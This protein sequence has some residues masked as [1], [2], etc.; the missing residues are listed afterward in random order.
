MQQLIQDLRYAV[1]GLIKRP[2]FTLIA[3]M[4]LA[5]G[6]GANSAIFSVVDGVL[7]RSL[8]L[9]DS[10]SLY[11]VHMGLATFNRFDG[12]LSYPEYQD[13]VQQTRSFQSIGAWVDGDAN[14]SEGGTAER[15]MIRIVLPSLLP[16]LGVE[17]VRGRNFL[18]EETAKGRDHVALIT[19]GLWQRRFSGSEDVIGKPIYLDNV[20][21]QI[22]GVLPHDFQFEKP[23]DLWV[24]LTTTD[25]E[26][27]VRNAHF[28]SVIGRLRPGVSEKSAAAD[29]SAVAK[30]ESA[31]FPD[32]FPPS[33]GFDFRARPYLEDIVGD[34]RLPLYVLLAAVGFVLLIACTNVANLLLA[35]AAPR[36]REIALRTALGARRWHLMR[37]LLTE[38]IL[39]AIIAGGIGVLLATWGTSALVALSPDSLPRAR[40]IGFDWRVLAFTGVIALTTGIVFGLLPAI[41]GPRV[42]LTDALKEGSRGSTAGS[43]RLRKILVV[44]EVALSLML[45]VGAGLMVRSF[46]HL[47]SVNPG[48]QTDHALTLRVSLPVPNSQISAADEDRFMSF[49]D[50]ALARLSELP[51]VTAAGA[52]NMIPLD[53]NGTDRLIEIEGYVPRDQSDMPDAQNRQATPGFFA[54]MGIPL[55]RGRLIERSDDNKAARVLVVN[56]E[57]VKRFFPN[58]DAIGKRIRLGKLT[59]DFPWAT[60]VGVVGDVRG[61]ALDE[62][63]EPTMYWPVAQIRATPS[64]TIVVRTLSDPAALAPS[65]RDAIAEIDG[66]QPIYD[67]QPLDQLVAKSLGQ[68]RF[69]LML[70][71]LFGVIALVL[72]AIGIYGVMAFAVTQRTQEIGIRMALGASALDV[73]KMVVGSGMFLAAIGVAVG[74]IGAFALTRLMASLLF[75]VSPTDLVTFGLVTAGLLMVALLACYIPARRATKVD[76]LVALRYE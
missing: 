56:Q 13:V 11:A 69:T 1:R 27:N 25:P 18:P 6:I 30:Y 28:L 19:Y 35:K 63:P 50:R 17:T 21:Y 44:A 24:P 36:Q 10:K 55:V 9:P 68:R 39:L 52:S 2:G 65:A 42:D 23:V 47:R 64:L 72:S 76:P 40:E 4:T 34:I 33:A 31:T 73:L 62:P 51:G 48:F 22:V 59:S 46:S 74:L 5:L 60:I 71:V 53:G 29:L 16:T 41:W 75:G 37:Q 7:L 45:L 58:G 14:L 32:M 43:G 57:F 20:D 49:F 38:S 8:P 61:F 66:A 67:V 3:V 70:M 15:A 12:P 26:I 54:A